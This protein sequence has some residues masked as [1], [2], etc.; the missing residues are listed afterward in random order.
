M[1]GVWDKKNQAWRLPDS[2]GKGDDLV[3]TPDNPEESKKEKAIAESFDI[4]FV[5]LNSGHELER[6]LPLQ[7]ASSENLQKIEGKPGELSKEQASGTSEIQSLEVGAPGDFRSQMH[8]HGL[9]LNDQQTVLKN[10]NVSEPNSLMMVDEPLPES[11]GGG[12][13]AV[14]DMFV[15]EVL[16]GAQGYNMSPAE[17]PNDSQPTSFIDF[18]PQDA[19]ASG[20]S[21]TSHEKTVIL[22]ESASNAH[23][24]MRAEESS[25]MFSGQSDLDLTL[26]TAVQPLTMQNDVIQPESPA[27]SDFVLNRA[28]TVAAESEVAKSV[29]Q[30]STTVEKPEVNKQ[31]V[32][33]E[34]AKT[35]GGEKSKPASG[36]KSSEGVAKEKAGSTDKKASAQQKGA[37]GAG[38]VGQSPKQHDHSAAQTQMPA[39]APLQKGLPKDLRIVLGFFVFSLL[40]AAILITLKQFRNSSEKNKMSIEIASQAPVATP[41]PSDKAS[42]SSSSNSVKNNVAA[43]EKKAQHSVAAKSGAEKPSVADNFDDELSDETEAIDEEDVESD[44]EESV[45]TLLTRPTSRYSPSNKGIVP[46]LETT[47]ALDRVQP[48]K[49]LNLLKRLPE[50]Y[51]VSDS[52][53]RTAIREVTGRYY[54]QVGAYSKALILFRQACPDPAKSS[55]IEICLHAARGLLVTGNYEELK[56]MLQGLNVRMIGQ[57]NQWREWLKLL[58]AASSIAKPNVENLVRFTDEMIDKGPYLTSEWNLQL[59]G[60]FARMLMSV[61]NTDRYEFLKTISG[62]RKKALEVR[63]APEQYGQDIG[64]YMMPSVLNILLRHHELPSLLV[65]SE[66]PETDSEFSLTAW[67][68]NVIAQSKMNEPRQTRARLAPLF[69]ERSFAPL[70]RIIEGHLAAQAGDFLGANSMIAEQIGIGPDKKEFTSE[71]ALKN[72]QTKQFLVATQRLKEL[73]FLYV[74]WLFLGVKVASGLSDK[75]TMK[76]MV[77]ALD[78]VRRRFPELSNEFQ[79]W[80]M[81]TRGQRLLGN[82]AAVEAALKES[83]RLGFTAH[84]KGFVAADKIWVLMKKG[85]KTD[86]KSLM[87]QSLREFPHHSRLLEL[88]AEF[89]AQ[90]GEDPSSYLKLEAEIPKRFEN[91]GRDRALLSFFTIR[92]LLTHF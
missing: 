30:G 34:K 35:G 37:S 76:S 54:L 77:F 80:S 72:A 46:L 57:K 25:S 40:L 15:A 14:Q 83:E 45:V 47:V 27:V 89:A 65:Q 38:K 12:S 2:P 50:S 10:E 52:L 60:Y 87:R 88:G 64:S 51:G 63:L 92:K 22:P 55:E 26:T 3:V 82:M 78:D 29:I 49:V 23:V 79:Y 5:N 75:D 32:A 69:A 58:E 6:S 67:M 18:A 42:A 61:P 66:E 81:L 84:E 90:W 62:S 28:T 36:G 20:A 71:L 17:G 9:L 7:A 16:K 85:K 43:V 48:R 74:E 4:D 24:E 53:E 91:R 13:A 59:S 21:N 56:E 86:A 19:F 8:D 39:V 70:A 44:E 41:N 33:S 11:L 68:F 1:N 31:P 73:P